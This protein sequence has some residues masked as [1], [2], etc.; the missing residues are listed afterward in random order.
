MFVDQF[1]K[2]N[3]FDPETWKRLSKVKKQKSLERRSDLASMTPL[4]LVHDKGKESSS[5]LVL[6]PI[7][8]CLDVA[9]ESKTSKK[10]RDIF[11]KLNPQENTIS[12]A[13][14]DGSSILPHGISKFSKNTVQNY[15][16]ILTILSE[17]RLISKENQNFLG[18]HLRHIGAFNKL[19][20]SVFERICGC[21]KL[22][23]IPARKCIFKQNDPGNCW[24]IILLG[25]IFKIMSLGYV[26][27]SIENGTDKNTIVAI[28]GPGEGFGEQAIIT[29]SE[30]AAST[31][32]ASS[33]TVLARVDKND[34]KRIMNFIRQMEKR[35]KVFF[36]KY[37][38]LLSKFDEISLRNLADR[39]TMRKFEP[40][41]LLIKESEVSNSVYFIKSGSASVY[42]TFQI[43]PNK[44]KTILVAKITR[45]DSVNEDVLLNR[46]KYTGSLVTV[47]ADEPL[48]FGAVLA[49][50]DLS[51][52]PF[53]YTRPEYLD[54]TQN[55]L[56]K[57][58]WIQ[59]RISKFRRLQTRITGEISGQG[60]ATEEKCRKEI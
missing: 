16:K 55:D 44:K 13:L 57:F 24:Y 18:L 46:S 9:T 41:S 48:E 27:V 6:P 25:I 3:G 26:R 31:F 33:P 40:G 39:V 14:D 42:K 37:V 15:E 22:E 35:E 36:L 49:Y 2:I 52:F 21:I 8:G 60:S 53:T 54:Y 1:Q 51:K 28:L 38:K 58:N 45:G 10:I 7:L 4:P 20:D 12:P 47:I 56:M 29:E 17:S 5:G 43:S 30:R 23:I 34:Y 32:A 50:V 59:G 19:T 11:R